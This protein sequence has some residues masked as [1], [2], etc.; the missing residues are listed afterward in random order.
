MAFP[1]V[2]TAQNYEC[3][4][5]KYV[6]YDAYLSKHENWQ[7]AC[8]MANHDDVWFL[9]AVQNYL[10][11]PASVIMHDQR[12]QLRNRDGQDGDPSKDRL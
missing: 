8:D 12:L 5:Y 4:Q 2:L 1:I 9:C 11:S 7:N 3:A 6:C 10:K